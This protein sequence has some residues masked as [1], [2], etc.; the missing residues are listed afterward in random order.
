LFRHEHGNSP[1]LFKPG[2]KVPFHIADMTEEGHVDENAWGSKVYALP[3]MGQ[4]R[5]MFTQ[6]FGTWGV[7]RVCQRYHEVGVYIMQPSTGE[8]VAE[9]HFMGDYGGAYTPNEAG[10]NNPGNVAYRPTACM[11]Q[12]QDAQINPGGGV[13]HIPLFV[14]TD[15]LGYEPWTLGL[16]RVTPV[17]G[18]SVGPDVN[19]PSLMQSC[20]AII[21]DVP[22]TRGS[23]G[24]DR[25]VTWND[26]FGLQA[27][28]ASTTANQGRFCTT[29]KAD[30]VVPCGTAGSIEQFVKP[31]LSAE[32]DHR[33]QDEHARYDRVR[34][35]NGNWDWTSPWK[36]LMKFNN[37]E[38]GAAICETFNCTGPN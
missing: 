26:H 34:L 36:R 17:L 10:P 35:P 15:K 23:D 2:F 5:W 4:Y 33:A 32:I 16:G 30:A 20:E 18:L 21:C 31:G 27:P 14:G 12:A 29:A 37:D 25:F 11:N 1:D 38:G 24:S 28:A 19:T 9:L 13:K 8:L 7:A 6:H 3:T 22:N